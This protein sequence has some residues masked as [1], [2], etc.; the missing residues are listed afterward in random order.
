MID[1]ENLIECLGVKGAIAGLEASDWTIAEL[2]EECGVEHFPHSKMKKHDVVKRIVEDV[3]RRQTKHPDE[4][5]AMDADQLRSYFATVR[6]SREE[7]LELLATLD[8]RPGS[9]VRKNLTEFAAQEI[10]DIGMYRRVA[11]G[12]KPTT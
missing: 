3:R 12:N 5:M 4:L 8:I 10:S 7:I 1:V 6:M 11:K 2:I 9:I